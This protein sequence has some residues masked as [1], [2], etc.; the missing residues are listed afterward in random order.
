MR[1][2]DPAVENLAGIYI[3]TPHSR[4]FRPVYQN[5]ESFIY[6]QDSYWYIGRLGER[7][8]RSKE[9]G[10]TLVPLINWQKRKEGRWEDLKRKD[11]GD[12]YYDTHFQFTLNITLLHGIILYCTVLYCTVLYSTDPAYSR[13]D[14]T[15]PE[16]T[17]LI[18]TNRM[19]VYDEMLELDIEEN[20][21]SLR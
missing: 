14:M 2:S 15:K 13:G 9:T 5:E 17:K 16:L 7:R 18:E 8:V 1:T 3:K 20:D 4:D 19:R 10:G 6:Y 21:V 11:G 12:P